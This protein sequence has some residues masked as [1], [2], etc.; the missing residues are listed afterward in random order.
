M[1]QRQNGSFT[2]MFRSEG[3][4]GRGISVQRAS[5]PFRSIKKTKPHKA[6]CTVD[7]EMSLS[8][9]LQFRTWIVVGES[10]LPFEISRFS[11]TF[12]G[13]QKNAQ[14]GMAA[15]RTA[16]LRRRENSLFRREYQARKIMFSLWNKNIF[17]GMGIGHHI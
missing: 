12:K 10:K 16:A 9:L 8:V 5:P 13:N 4:L 6:A 14:G 2:G 7:V 3:N 11:C 17:R 1:V 15:E